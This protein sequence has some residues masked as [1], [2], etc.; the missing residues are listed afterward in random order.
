VRADFPRHTSPPQA[1]AEA[2]KLLV[3]KYAVQGFPTLL[4]LDAAGKELHRIEG[5][6][7]E[8]SLVWVG[9]LKKKLNPENE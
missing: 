5:Y 8:D 1:Q 6:E 3:H 7:N 4:L 9:A 2:N